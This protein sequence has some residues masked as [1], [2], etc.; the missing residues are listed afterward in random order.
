MCSKHVEAWNKTYGCDDTRGCLMQFW[1]PD[2]EHVC[3]KHVEAWNKT[4]GCDDTR[5]CVMQFWPPDDE[6]MCSKHVE[7]WNKLTVK[8]KFCV[9]GWL[10]TE[11]N[12][13][14]C[15]VSKTSKIF[16]FRNITLKASSQFNFTSEKRLINSNVDSNLVEIRQFFLILSWKT[17]VPG[18]KY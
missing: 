17:S 7:A 9:S 15:T 1:P 8:Q 6:H 4:Y 16:I 2:D 11:I 18:I 10:I 3:S 13:L 14:R 12:I 5:G